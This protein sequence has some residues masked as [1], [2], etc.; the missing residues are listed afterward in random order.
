MRAVPVQEAAPVGHLRNEVVIRFA[1]V[2]A[3]MWGAVYLAWRA[4]ETWQGTEPA[5]FVLLFACELF[6]WAMLVSFCFLAW[7]I[8][9]TKRPP[10]RQPHSVDVLVCTY[11]EGLDVLEAT[12]LGCAGITYPHV[13]WVLDDGRRDSVRELAAHAGARY[14]TRLDTRHAKAGNINHALRSVAGDLLLVLDA[15]HVPQPDILD[16][17]VGYFDDPNV[18]VVQTPHD[19][20]NQDSFQ[21][22]A[23]GRHD[24]SMFFEVILPGKDR[25]NGVF[26]CGSA[27]LIRRDAL[28]EVGGVATETIAEDFHTT[29]KMHGRGWKT[30]YHGET[31]VQGLAP[32]DLASYLLQR[33]RWARGNLT[34]FRTPQNPLVAPNLSIAQR[35]SYLS[36][37]LA[38][39][40]PLQRLGLLAVLTVMM[41]SGQLP[42][43]ATLFGFLVFWTPW[44]VVDLGASTLLCRGRANLWDGT[45]SLLLTMEIFARAVLVI[46]RP[47]AS[48]FKVTPKDGIDDGGWQALRQL[49]LV[50]G[51]AVVLSVALVVRAL[52]ALGVALLP[53]LR[54]APLVIG[55]L[56]W[57]WE[58][59]LV[60]A[61]LAKV[62]HRRQL[63][64]HYRTPTEVAATVDGEAVRIVDL[65]PSG[66]GLVGTRALSLGQHVELVAAL[67][68][69]NARSQP[70]RLDMVVTMC[71]TD[72]AIPGH[73]RIG[74]SI[75][76][77]S[78]EDHD[79][80]IAYCHVAAA[81]S[82]LT[83]SGR[84]LE[85]ADAVPAADQAAM[86]T[87]APAAPPAVW[88]RHRHRRH[89]V[90]DRRASSGL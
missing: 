50:I 43:H 5:L 24:Q 11:D 20:S 51:I 87:A 45:Y 89:P 28:V 58:L 48:T 26:W 25:H 63:R 80:L 15:D 62:S 76:A 30:R 32:H 83:K 61:V 71:H 73:W 56:L 68:D 13:T 27:A 88:G 2:V 46:L 49:R 3:V 4:I 41:L 21:H 72:A 54:G 7:R 36:S 44:I 64:R 74:G 90:S 14:I 19:F 52:T 60:V 33:D 75:E 84:L 55:L 53:S 17:T 31:L 10:I 57:A 66:A 65:T 23:T 78:G 16:A 12:L 59:G 38:Y 85:S 79:R 6:G 67:P 47:T 22:F 1:A 70:L 9:A 42:F 40:V 86:A 8:P 82:R 35:V 69:L 81:R 34:V 29:I 77:V 39:F 18:A 37:L